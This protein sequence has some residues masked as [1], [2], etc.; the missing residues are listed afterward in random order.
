MNSNPFSRRAARRIGIVAATLLSCG[1]ASYAPLPLD[2]QASGS[3]SISQTGQGQ[4]MPPAVP[5]VDD[6][7][8]LALNDNPDLRAVRSQHGIARAQV[9]EAGIAPNLRSTRPMGSCW[10]ARAAS[11]RWLAG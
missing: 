11:P 5:S 2:K 6:I 3:N 1:C 8:L 4:S 9:L 10:A 7:V